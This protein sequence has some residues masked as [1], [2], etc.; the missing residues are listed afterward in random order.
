[1]SWTHSHSV[2]L[3]PLHFYADHTVTSS[4]AMK[5]SDSSPSVSSSHQSES[6]PSDRSSPTTTFSSQASTGYRSPS[7]QITQAAHYHPYATSQQSQPCDNV[8]KKEKCTKATRGK[9]SNRHQFSHLNVSAPKA[10]ALPIRSAQQLQTRLEDLSS[11]LGGQDPYTVMMKLKKNDK[12]AGNR[13]AQGVVLS[14]LEEQVFRICP[15]LPKTARASVLSGFHG[16]LTELKSWNIS[17]DIEE[18]A[19]VKPFS[20][21]KTDLL[22]AIL[23]IIDD[24]SMIIE[25]AAEE[26]ASIEAEILA[27]FQSDPSKEAMSVLLLHILQTSMSHRITHASAER[28]STRFQG[29]LMRGTNSSV[30]HKISTSFS[31]I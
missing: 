7:P 2:R 14:C 22:A 17:K 12:E 29:P 19:G 27:L 15:S 1:M 28:G 21:K 20:H 30:P 18:H 9:V 11:R 10:H 31:R 23:H 4:L 16:G 8:V 3:P 6:A 25:E 24:S 13:F 26:R 5:R